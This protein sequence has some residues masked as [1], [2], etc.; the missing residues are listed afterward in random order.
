MFELMEELASILRHKRM[1]R[2]AIDFD[3]KEAKVLVDEE[4]HPT[5]VVTRERS[6]AERLIEEF[7]LAANETIA[8]H[9]HWLEVPLFT[10]FTKTRKRISYSGFLSLS[11][12]SA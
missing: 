12:I 5:D 8:E 2:G 9:F 3:F 11:R 4:G 6:V 1:N 7:M 10:E